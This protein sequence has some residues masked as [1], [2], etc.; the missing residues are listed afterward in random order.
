VVASL[1][2]LNELLE[3]HRDLKGALKEDDLF[4]VPC[5]LENLVSRLK[6][7]RGGHLFE[8]LILILPEYLDRS[9]HDHHNLHVVSLKLPSAELRDVFEL[10]FKLVQVGLPVKGALVSEVDKDRVIFFMV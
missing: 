1:D 7:H 9:P 2:N 4:E 10:N 5:I 8:A 6:S 3:P